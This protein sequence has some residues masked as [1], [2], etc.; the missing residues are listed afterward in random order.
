MEALTNP[1]RVGSQG[2]GVLGQQ[3]HTAGGGNGSIMV[4]MF[5]CLCVASQK[6]FEREFFVP[7]RTD[8][9]VK[10][11]KVFSSAAQSCL[12]CHHSL[13]SPPPPCPRVVVVPIPTAAV[14]TSTAAAAATVPLP[15]R[16][17]T[18]D[19]VLLRFRHLTRIQGC[20]HPRLP[21]HRQR[22]AE[23]VVA[24]IWRCPPLHNYSRRHR[25]HNHHPL[26]SFTSPPPH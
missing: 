20:R 11:F 5:V 2:W 15:S 26:S 21:A 9:G 14:F 13:P 8:L 4:G 23:G 19:K 25:H 7:T 17:I 24:I 10:L 22:Q 3:N 18:G 12:C 16:V 6:P 1:F